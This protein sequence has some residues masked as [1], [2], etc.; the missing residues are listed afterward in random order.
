[1]Q[2]FQLVLLFSVYGWAPTCRDEYIC[3][4]TVQELV[5]K[6]SGS[7]LGVKMSLKTNKHEGSGHVGLNTRGCNVNTELQRGQRS[8]GRKIHT[9]TMR[10]R[11][12]EIFFLPVCQRPWSA[13]ASCRARSPKPPSP[14]TCLRWPGGKHSTSPPA[15]GP[16]GRGER[17]FLLNTKWSE[18]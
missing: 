8:R 14:S 11:W 16:A 4:L 12:A 1:M 3:C 2:I 13:W 7:H 18:V 6:I 10:S 5:F 17:S 9:V 15:E